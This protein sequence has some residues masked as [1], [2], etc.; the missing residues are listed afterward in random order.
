VPEIMHG[1]ATEVSLNQLSWTQHN[2]GKENH[3][4]KVLISRAIIVNAKYHNNN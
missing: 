1:G 4:R 3:N 2:L